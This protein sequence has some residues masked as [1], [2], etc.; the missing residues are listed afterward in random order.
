MTRDD[1]V[2]ISGQRHDPLTPR[3]RIPCSRAAPGRSMGLFLDPR[4]VGQT[5]CRSLE[6]L[7][8]DKVEVRAL[9]ASVPICEATT[10]FLGPDPWRL[11]DLRGTMATNLARLGV[12][13]FVI[14]RCLNH[15][16]REVTGIY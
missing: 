6:V 1:A 7:A 11:H 13:R 5:H 10:W 9:T 3:R 12:S 16:D 4:V 2:V 15:A 14:A 8:A